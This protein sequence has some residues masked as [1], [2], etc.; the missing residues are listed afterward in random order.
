MAIKFNEKS[1]PEWV[2]VTGIGFQTLNVSILEHEVSK[3]VGNIDAGINRGGVEIAISIFINPVKNMTIL[4][5]SDELKRFLMGDSWSVSELI[6]L[7]QPNKF[8]NARVSNAVDIT[9][10]FTH[11]ESEIIFHASDPKKYDVE[12]TVVNSSNGQISIDYDGMEKTPILI[13]F[14]ANGSIPNPRF[15]HEELGKEIRML[16]T[17]SS[18]QT[19]E[20]DNRTNKILIN[21]SN[22]KQHMAF[23]S[24][25]LEL[26]QGANT[27]TCVDAN[28][29]KRDF[30]ITYRKAD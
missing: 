5:Q 26:I 10:A 24:N 8:Y 27:I 25:W 20:I 3:R 9:D 29:T 15:T 4:D 19:L 21:N 28:N 16:T 7:E 11:G 6:L 2:S 13:E 14:K 22:A 12:K 30:K 1:L 23:E 17:M 18:G